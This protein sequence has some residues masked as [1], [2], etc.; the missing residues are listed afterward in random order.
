MIYKKFREPVF[1]PLKINFNNIKVSEITGYM[2]AGND[3]IEVKLNDGK[4][5]YIKMERSKVACFETEVNNISI[6]KDNRLYNLIPNILEYKKH[7]DKDIIVLQ[8]IK[9]SKLSSILKNTTKPIKYKYLYKYGQELARIH[10]ISPKFFKK[11]KQRVINEKPTKDTYK[12]FDKIITPFIE[13]LEKH[14]FNKTYDTFIHGDF[15]YGNILWYYGKINGIIDYEY[16][17]KGLKEQD[18]A[19]ALV[20]RPGQTFMDN[21]N[22]INAFLDGYK[23]VGTY[24]KEK[25][26]WCLINGCVHFYLMNKNN[27]EYRDKIIQILKQIIK[28]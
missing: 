24:D 14:D 10:S 13:Y 1:D 5:A 23:S 12:E 20:L 19:W 9:G 11:A 15:H 4:E 18:I 6:I 22:D 7:N 27:I 16:S 21:I 28:E 2:P 3:V 17:G 26:K 25:L 8:K